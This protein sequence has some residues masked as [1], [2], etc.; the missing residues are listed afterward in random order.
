MSEE[1]V[2]LH[3]CNIHESETMDTY[4]NKCKQPICRECL[5]TKHIGHDIDKIMNLYRKV[6][7]ERLCLLQGLEIKVSSVKDRNRRRLRNVKCSN[8][9]LMTVN[10]A[11]IE[12]KRAEMHRMVDELINLHVGSLKDVSA[13]L[14]ENISKEEE[15]FLEE[16]F[17]LRIMFEKFQEASL[18]ELDLIN[19]YQKLT[20]KVD[21]KETIDVSKFCDKHVFEE[22][23]IDHDIL[24]TMLGEMKLIQQSSNKVEIGASLQ[25]EKRPVYSISPISQTEAWVSYMLGKEIQ[26]L[27]QDGMCIR[28]V[29]KETKYSSFIHQDGAFLVCCGDQNTI[30]K[31]GMTANSSV[32]MNTS[33][34]RARFIGKALNGNILVSLVD[35]VSGSRTDQSK[36]KVQ[37]VT[38]SG[39]VLQSYEYG[40]DGTS[41]VNTSC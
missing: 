25:H 9:S 35:E 37:M 8:E 11:N 17:E 38:P 22:G 20:S 1:K 32:W 19:Y 7:N 6:K 33:P 31:I 5:K 40:G 30:L 23:V 28:S 39:D 3:V 27:C 13:K 12:K 14:K 18:S 21:E 24:R 41:C 2:A 16:D 34:L 26:L 29:K 15:H 10:L 36:R 4:C